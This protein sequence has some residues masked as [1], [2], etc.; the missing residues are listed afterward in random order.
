ML[1]WV[2]RDCGWENQ[3]LFGEVTFRWEL[4]EEDQLSRDKWQ[5]TDLGRKTELCK[6]PDMGKEVAT[7]N[8]WGEKKNVAHWGRVGDM[9]CAR[10]EGTY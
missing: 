10:H 3:D 9:R 6:D 1:W 5:E 7:P 2:M 8:E 4:K